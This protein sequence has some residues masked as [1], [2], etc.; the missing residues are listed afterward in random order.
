MNY[1]PN[2]GTKT[3]VLGQLGEWE[4]IG[5]VSIDS[6]VYNKLPEGVFS[7]P[8]RHALKGVPVSHFEEDLLYQMKNITGQEK[9]CAQIS[10]IGIPG[11]MQIKTKYIFD[12][13]KQK[14]DPCKY[15][16]RVIFSRLY[17]FPPEQFKLGDVDSLNRL[18][19]SPRMRQH[20]KFHHSNLSHRN[21]DAFLRMHFKASG[22][23]AYHFNVSADLNEDRGKIIRVSGPCIIKDKSRGEL[24]YV[25][26]IPGRWDQERFFEYLYE[27]YRTFMM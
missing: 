19:A 7:V 5:D 26:N 18:T 12:R 24:P 20:G 21:P 17:D 10:L 16:H 6:S 25:K 8:F 4:L 2:L 27:K 3:P 11:C 14:A 22:I 1:I 23:V 9:P 15:D 13:E